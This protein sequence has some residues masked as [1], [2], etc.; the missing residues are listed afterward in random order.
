M[1]KSIG[2]KIFDKFNIIIMAFLCV[3]F[4]YPYLNQV[5]ISLNDGADTML[6]GITIFPRKFT[7]VNYEAIIKNQDI[8]RAFVLTAL[9]ALIHTGFTVVIC[10]G[11]AYG[12]HKKDMPFRNAIIWFLLIPGYIPVGAIPVF[13][14]YRHLHLLN[15]VLVF[16]IPGMFTFYNM[17]VI[18]SYLD[19]LPDG[20]EEAAYVEGANEMQI[21]FKIILPLCM[22]VLATIA[23]WTIVGSWN[24]WT[25]TLYYVNDRKLYQLQYVIMQLI[26]QSE[27]IQK[28]TTEAAITGTDVSN[29][30]PTSESIKSAAIIF[31]TLPIVMSY[32]FLQKYF[33]KGIT[34]GA[35]KG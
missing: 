5:A 12:A 3:I 22:P 25:P 7:W 33:V 2:E 35:V 28:M 10:L 13:I 6:G 11:A 8:L 29:V 26:K 9:V 14:L 34:V 18:R 21:L 4:I 31:S 20:L 32:P 30:Q 23:L 16:I 1:K 15:N 19:G 27:T 17:V 24:S